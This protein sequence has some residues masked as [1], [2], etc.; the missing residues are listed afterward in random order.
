MGENLLLQSENVS[1]H[2]LS[3]VGL[4]VIRDKYEF[5]FRFSRLFLIR[6]LAINLTLRKDK[7]EH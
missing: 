5:R 3:N 1:V 2:N 4:W 7:L 6:E